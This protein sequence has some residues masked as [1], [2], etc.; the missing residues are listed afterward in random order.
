MFD[1]ARVSWRHGTIGFDGS[2]WVLTD[3]GSTNGTYVNGQRTQVVQ[4][5]PGTVV[6]L[7]NPQDGPLLAFRGTA[8]E[9]AQAAQSNLHEARTQLAGPAVQ[10][11]QGA[12]PQAGMPPQQG[13]PPQ[14]MPPQ[15][16]PPQQQVP[17]QAQFA[18]QPTAPRR[19]A[20]GQHPEAGG[21]RAGGNVQPTAIR[22]LQG[23]G[24]VK[25]GRALDN[26]VVV[27]DLQ[28][29]RYHATLNLLPDGRAELVDLGSH[30]GTYVNGQQVR[31]QVIG[32]DDVVGIGHSSF[33]LVGNSLQEFEDTGEVS[34]SAHNLN[35]IVGKERMKILDSVSFGLN[36][37]SLVAVLG[38]SGAG[39]STLVKALTGYRPADEGS[40]LYDGRNLYREYAELRS[41]I[42]LVP[43]DDIL[44]SQLTVRS[45][46]RYAA[47]LRFPGDTAHEERNARVEEVIRELGLEQRAGN[48]ITALSGGQRKRVSVALE[49]LTKPSLLFLDE[50]TSGLDPGMERQV[51]QMLRG[52]ADDGRTCVVITHATES[53][54]L[55]DRVLVLAVGGSV[56]YFGPPD[57][58]LPF[59]GVGRW[60]EVFD[61]LDRNK[62]F[63]WKGRYRSS[64]HHQ[65]YS[66]EL[67]AQQA[68]AAQQAAQQQMQPGGA[69]AMQPT[70]RPPR[71]SSWGSQLWTL[72][73][74]YAR[75]ISSDK[76]FLGLSVALPLILGA[77]V[78]VLPNK[79]GFK[80]P[81]P[82]TNAK[83][84][85]FYNKDA[86]TSLMIMVLAICFTGAANSVRELVKER[87]IYERERA[88]GLS[89]SAYMMS[90]VIVLGIVTSI[91][92]IVIALI[93]FN[94]RAL[95]DKGLLL[96]SQ[97]PFLEMTFTLVVLGIA[98]LMIGMV[99]S[100]VVK[101]S[102]M[103]MPLLVLFA[104]VQVAFAGALFKIFGSAGVEQLAWLMPARWGLGALGASININRLSPPWDSSGKTDPIWNNTV[105]QWSIDIGILVAM[106][107]VCAFLV[108]RF[109]R[110]HE[111]E[112]MRK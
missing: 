96:S 111:P 16:M 32:P 42:G 20:S 75:V 54:D 99:L 85:P 108:T 13:M 79:Y 110:R 95:P 91:Q 82:P 87:V 97:S 89:R 50:P 12:P 19:P 76:G 103:T 70:A 47:Q 109:L 74:R 23:V 18:Q 104:V 68:Q 6:N 67:D 31:Q 73:R 29:S 46:L 34:F 101:S 66:G 80:I 33:R 27:D 56:A 4:L 8:P 64:E 53:L 30:N 5:M 106:A 40:V 21:N 38:P 94:Y 93:G 112:V 36:S 35:V 61:M 62:E 78:M 48:R 52:L 100:A 15:G 7:G 55:C 43:Q 28:S 83:G 59:F 3:H 25:I 22:S 17:A 39:K 26:D 92:G 51:M 2:G 72:C 69:M 84:F 44:H 102:E 37:K 90:K 10:M 65:L 58:A 88:T 77:L 60:S 81:D 98:S 24:V 63:D 14:G 105:G 107:L 1:D 45:A 11:P 86:V 71:P 9:P 41:R 49:L 57:E